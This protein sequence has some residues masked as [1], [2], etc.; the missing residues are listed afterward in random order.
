MV[1]SLNITLT[2]AYFPG[3]YNGVADRL[4]RKKLLPEWHLLTE[5]KNKIFER[6]RFP[7]IDLFPSAK[8]AILKRY[9]SM[10]LR[11]RHAEF[12]DAFNQVWNYKLAWVFPPANLIS[13]VL[14]LLNKCRGQYVIIAPK[15][16]RTF[17]MTDL[18]NRGR[19]LPI[20]IT[21]L[22]RS[23]IDVNRIRR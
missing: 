9:V 14:S 22:S 6:W 2:A 10:D 23:L 15:Q 16:N 19:E 3:R 13:K 5:V 8:S 17:W 1:D 12:I 18:P 20:T 4:S 11:D 21:E 7:T